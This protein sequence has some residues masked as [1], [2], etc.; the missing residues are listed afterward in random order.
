MN[1][2]RGVHVGPAENLHDLT[3]LVDDGS[4]DVRGSHLRTLGVNQQCQVGRDRANVLDDSFDAWP[5]RKRVFGSI[6]RC[7][8]LLC[9]S[10]QNYKS[11]LTSPN[12]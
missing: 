9:Y 11:Y 3:R 8:H 6:H 4:G 1:V 10:M 5:A 12:D 2:V 7:K